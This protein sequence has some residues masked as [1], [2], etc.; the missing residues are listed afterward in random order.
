MVRGGTGRF[1][2]AVRLQ[3]HLGAG[4]SGLYPHRVIMHDSSEDTLLICQV[5]CPLS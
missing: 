1:G 3:E 2:I 4:L 5:H